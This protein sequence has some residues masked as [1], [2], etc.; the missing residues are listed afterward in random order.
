MFV[1]DSLTLV[2][3]EMDWKRQCQ[4]IFNQFELHNDLPADESNPWRLTYLRESFQLFLS[5]F[6]ENPDF[7]GILQEI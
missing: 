4:L 1:L 2:E 6:E 3:N 7:K 5:L